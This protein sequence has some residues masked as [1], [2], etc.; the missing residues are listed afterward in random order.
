MLRQILALT[1]VG[2]A[3]GCTKTPAAPE[4]AAA[5][6]DTSGAYEVAAT[7][8]DDGLRLTITAK[9]GYKLNAEYPHNFKPDAANDSVRFDAA[10]YDL[11]EAS[12]RTACGKAPD[13]TCTM[14]VTIPF[15]ASAGAAPTA[16]GV[17]AFSVCD[18]NIC[19]IEKVP[20]KAVVAA[21]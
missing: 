17:A 16:S 1:L 4:P 11:W 7:A 10:R 20:V 14:E 8:S 6:R 21:L 19:L 9:K 5:P 18:P 15:E 3:A 2:L 12:Q 13:D